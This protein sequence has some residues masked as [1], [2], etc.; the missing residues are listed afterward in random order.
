MKYDEPNVNIVNSPLTQANGLLTVVVDKPQPAA[1]TPPT[2]PVPVLQTPFVET[3]SVRKVETIQETKTP[4]LYRLI[5][6]EILLTL[7]KKFSCPECLVNGSL[8]LKEISAKKKGLASNLCLV[9]NKCPY[10]ESFYTSQNSIGK[11]FDVNNRIV[12]AMRTIGQGYAG[13][14][15]LI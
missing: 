5:D 10:N 6:T 4:E 1:A 7:F 13:L 2:A 8:S 9:C 12:Y 15:K 3:A 14:E 11:T